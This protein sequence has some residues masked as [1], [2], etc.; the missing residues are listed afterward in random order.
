VAMTV[1]EIIEEVDEKYPNALTT[2]SKVRKLNIVQGEIFRTVYKKQTT[3]MY[4]LVAGNPFY[5]LDFDISKILYVLVNGAEYDSEEIEDRNAEDPYWYRY[6]NAIGLYPTPAASA[7]NGLLIVHY[8]EPAKL[9]DTNL[10][11]TPDF[12]PDFH[13][14]LVYAL[15]IHLAESDQRFDA[16]NGFIIQYKSLLKDFKRANPEPELPP[17]RV[18]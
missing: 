4:D 13:N 16:A 6:E 7:A 15:C 5:P 12:D 11:V 17:V 14:L 18:R 8:L 9:T 2:R 3:T 1:A 10:N